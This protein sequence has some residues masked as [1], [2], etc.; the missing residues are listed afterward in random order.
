VDVALQPLARADAP[1]LDRLLQ[2]YEYDYSEY[3]GVDLDEHGLFPTVDVETIW[4][5]HDR[6]FLIRADGHPAGFALVTRHDAYLGGGQATLLAEFF[7]VRKY[8]RQGVGE[9]AVVQL[10]DRFPGRW[11]LATLTANLGAQ[12]FW[13]RV[14]GRHRPAFRE[15]P[16]GC[17]RWRGPIWTFG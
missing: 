2:L 5:E 11:E 8:R 3:G 9:R 1:V 13:R 4:G 7:V 15:V 10:L 12:A 16:D 6:N 17:D 14:L